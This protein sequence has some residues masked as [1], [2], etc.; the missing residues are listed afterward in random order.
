MRKSLLRGFK[1]FLTALGAALPEKALHNLNMM[2]NYMHLGHW[3]R[4]QGF[5][6]P[7]RYPLRDGVFNVAAENIR[8][9]NV[10]YLEFG[11][12]QGASMR[13]WSAVLKNPGSHLHGFDS[14]EGLPE[15]FDDTG[16]KYTRGWFSTGGQLPQIDDP[17]VTFFKGWFSETLPGYSLPDHEVLF[18]NIDAD[19]YS[20]TVDVLHALRPHIRP[21]TYLY[22][23]DMSRPDHEPRALEEFMRE[24]GLRFRPLAADVTLNNVLFICEGA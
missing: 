16:G 21:G 12:Y 23:D 19:L 4:S 9:A 6:V 8:D 3:M 18:I 14:F 10:L 11:V 17:R 20:S 22:M 24:S 13:W 15:A 1:R 5:V 2:L 7:V